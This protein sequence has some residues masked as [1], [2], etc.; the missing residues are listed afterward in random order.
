[1]SNLIIN[2]KYFIM[3]KLGE[4]ASSKVFLVKDMKS[5]KLFACKFQNISHKNLIENETNFLSQFSHKNIIKKIDDGEFELQHKKLKFIIFDYC[6]HGRLSDYICFGFGERYGKY[7][8]NII[9]E[10]VNE[11]H[12]FG[13]AHRDLKP[14]NILLDRWFN[15]KI[16]DF[17]FCTLLNGNG[18]KNVLGTFCY[19]A[20]EIFLGRKYDGKKIDIF[21]LGIILFVIVTGKKFFLVKETE[22]FYLN[23]YKNKNVCENYEKFISN[24]DK[25][26]LSFSLDFRDLCFKMIKFNPIE[27]PDYFDI[28][29]HDWLK[30]IDVNQFEMQNH[31]KWR[32]EFVR[33]KIEEDKILKE[34]ENEK[35]CESFWFL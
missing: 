34:I 18:L 5:K 9:L 22:L 10:T 14:E 25:E 33:C 4:G 29:N 2:N 3:Q 11:I 15:V 30:N 27:R 23:C 7:L 20:P 26:C 21:S 19:A 17:G 12:N 16:G 32:D 31:F 13:F 8:F 35:N 1:M 24:L 6:E 28:K